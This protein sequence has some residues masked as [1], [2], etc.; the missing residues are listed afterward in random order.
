MHEREHSSHPVCLFIYHAMILE[1]TDNEELIL[2]LEIAW[3]HGQHLVNLI[4]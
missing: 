2:E 3:G 1:I 4:K